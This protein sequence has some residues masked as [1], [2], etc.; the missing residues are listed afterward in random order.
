MGLKREVRFRDELDQFLLE[1]LDSDG[2]VLIL[3]EG[4]DDEF[5]YFKFFD[6]NNANIRRVNGCQGIIELRKFV[7]DNS[8]ITA[9]AIID[10]DFA[11][12]NN[13]LSSDENIFYADGHDYEMMCFKSDCVR[14]DLLENYRIEY[15]ERPFADSFDDL[16]L[17]SYI[18]WYNYTYHLGYEASKVS[19]AEKDKSQLSSFEILS[20][21]IN[22][23][24]LSARKKDAPEGTDPNS[25]TVNPIEKDLLDAFIMQHPSPDKY[26]VTRGHSFIDRIIVHLKALNPELKQLNQSGLK[27]TMNPCY[28]SECFKATVLYTSLS[29]WES[30]KGK[31]IL[32][33]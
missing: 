19:V 17:L 30:K 18:Q 6:H 1:H 14:H 11:R 33:E 16:S 3:V 26:E 22:T 13:D 29:V 15:S 23:K 4:K 25:I 28:S 12:L 2:K 7:E 21:E 27:F 31:K 32:A 9:I 24:T 10:S 5:F 8:N 20:A